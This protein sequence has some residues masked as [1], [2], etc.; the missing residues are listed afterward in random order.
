[1]SAPGPKPSTVTV[2]KGVTWKTI[3]IV[4]L[5]IASLSLLAA[6]PLSFFFNMNMGNWFGNIPLDL[7][8]KPGQI[9]SWFN[10][11]PMQM[12]DPNMQVPDWLQDY[13]NNLPPGTQI[14]DWLQ[15]WLQNL[16]GNMT[17]QLPPGSI[18]WWLAAG[19]LGYLLG[20]G[21]LP[22]GGGV[23]GSGG[24]P[25]TGGVGGLPGMGGSMGN[26]LG[27]FGTPGV[28]LWVSSDL[29]FRYWRIRSYDFF[30]GKTWLIGDNTTAAYAGYNAPGKNYTVIMSMDYSTPG[31]GVMP[32]PLLWDR[33]LVR[34]DLQVLNA[35]GLPPI[36]MTWDLMEDQYGCVFWNATFGITG[37]YY[38]VY[39]VTWDESVNVPGIESNVYSDSPLNFVADPPGTQD[40]LQL[41]NL[42]QYPLVMVDLLKL[43]TNPVLA[44]KNTYQTA[45]AVM[46]YFKTRWYWTPYRAQIPGQ[47]FD[48]NYLL[49]HGYGTSADFASNYVTYLRAMNISSRLIWG[50]IGFQNDTQMSATVGFPLSKITHSHFWAEV[51]IPNATNNGGS[52]VQFD[53]SPFPPTMWQ[54]NASSPSGPLIEID[55]RRN[56]TRVETS[57]YTMRFDASVAY[58]VPQN[59][60]TNSFNLAGTLLRDGK[61]L[62]ITWLNEP[63]QYK[64]MDVTDNKLLGN[65]SGAYNN[66]AFNI[67]ST[68]GLHRFNVSFYAVQNETRVTCNGTTRVFI[69]MLSP[70][71]VYR[72]VGGSFNVLANI[73]D[74]SNN[75]PIANADLRGYIVE[76]SLY[77]TDLQGIRLSDRTGHALSQHYF[78]SNIQEGVYKFQKQF[79]GTFLANYPDPYPDYQVV[80]PSSAAR[81]QNITMTVVASLNITLSVIGGNGDILPRGHDITFNGYLTFDNATPIQNGL[82]T[83]WWVNSTRRYNITAGYTNSFG[84][85]QGKYKVPNNYND[86]PNSNVFIFANFSVVYGNCTTRTTALYRIRCSNTTNIVFSLTMGAKGYAIRGVDN[87]HVWGRLWDPRGLASTTGQQVEILVYGTNQSA[88][89]LTVGANGN[90]QGDLPPPLGQNTGQYNLCARFNGQWTYTT[91]SPFIPSSASLSTVNNSHHVVIVAKTYLTKTPSVSAVGRVVTPIPMIAGDPVYIGG[92]LLFDNGTG[93]GARQVRAY[94]I[95]SGVTTAIDSNNT[96]ASGRYNITYIIPIGQPTGNVI[97]KVN[98]SAGAVLSSYILNASADADPPVYWAVN[99]SISSLTPKAALRGQTILVLNGRV[100]EKH[101]YNVP[102]ERVYIKFGGRNVLDI[103]NA[104]VSAVTDSSGYFSDVFIVSASF[105]VNALYRVNVSLTNSSFILNYEKP[106]FIK[107]NTTT[108]ILNFAVDRTGLIGETIRVTGNLVDNLGQNQN[109]MV[110][111]LANGSEIHREAVLGSISWDLPIPNNPTL[112][113]INNLTLYHNGSAVTYPSFT[114][115][116]QNVPKGADVRITNIAGYSISENITLNTGSRVTVTGT[117]KDNVSNIA[118]FNRQ[119]RL[120]YNGS[121]L[122]LGTTDVNGA[123]HIQITIPAFAGN[124]TIYVE[125]IANNIYTSEEITVYTIIPP[126]IGDMFM[127]FLPWIIGAVVGIIV[128]YLSY[129][130]M[131]KRTRKQKER[132]QK[133]EGINLEFVKT[134][135]AALQQGNRFQEAIIYAYYTYLELAQ[136]YYNL[137]RHPSQTAREFA[138]DMVKKVKIPPA[139]VYPFTTFYEEARFGKKEIDAN[140]FN[141]AFKL[142]EELHNL[143]MGGIKEVVKEPASTA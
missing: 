104:P 121:L 9:P 66:Y 28:N 100:V 40:Y 54:P 84:F 52:W 33:P 41:P 83:V 57:H 61:P 17:G 86:P 21:S 75:K 119:V 69:E 56:D 6:I 1:M 88:G 16:P 135:I 133:F 59:R 122:G 38:L 70:Q 65:R 71:Q 5:L 34:S 91:G 117:L 76:K 15:N 136:G 107:V 78:P 81:S 98:Y 134:K 24:V 125:F 31:Y 105:P 93:F 124:T 46:E 118:I 129:S 37:T 19:A 106:A 96:Q 68:V 67:N 64:Y 103:N 140:T 130:F 50:G 3:L 132:R 123:F 27:P 142:F 26:G 25:G 112:A 13:L 77:L 51:W 138:M 43:L 80:I 29:P 87:V 7:L 127:Q 62:V 55:I 63:V 47:D 109:G 48:P 108:S 2:T 73:T 36:N 10:Q 72:G 139:L 95:R 101:G 89:F 116:F 114:H 45:Q 8:P 42:M 39:N 11:T 110:I 44:S 131:A 97:I 12:P 18:P 94:W 85:Y 113:G 92:Y 60:I 49:T 126:S 32:L 23:P 102:N 115:L 58:N 120:Y 22:G 137:Q 111:L 141:E 14:P 74:A 143:I 82:V 90:F 4:G 35:S 20:N 99:V 30:E 79:N 128:L 53:P